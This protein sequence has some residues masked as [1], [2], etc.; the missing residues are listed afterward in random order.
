MDPIN[1]ESL[2]YTYEK[3]KF[4]SLTDCRRRFRSNW[5]C[6]RRRRTR[7]ATMTEDI[8][9]RR[10]KLRYR[11][12]YTGMKETDLLLGGFAERYLAAFD[13]AQ[14]DQYEAI[15]GAGDGRIL[16]WIMAK[17]AVPPVYNGT[18]MDLL[19]NFKIET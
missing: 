9:I 8:H 11:S 4:S 10:K 14:L 16:D 12:R 3:S 13:D 17:E 7:H 15:L 18:V 2:L 6:S 19:L 5:I 1:R